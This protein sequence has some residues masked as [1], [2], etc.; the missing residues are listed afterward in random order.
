MEKQG[1][2]D[3]NYYLR[4]AITSSTLHLLSVRLGFTPKPTFRGLG[5]EALNLFLAAPNTEQRQPAI[6]EDRNP[7]LFKHGTVSSSPLIGASDPSI[8]FHRR[9]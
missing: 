1:N 2:R 7:N 6:S 8:K 3:F 5:G 4:C 9:A